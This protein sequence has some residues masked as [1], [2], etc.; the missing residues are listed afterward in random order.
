MEIIKPLR[1]GVMTRPFSWRQRE[2][3]G[4]AV[5]ALVSLRAPSQLLHEQELWDVLEDE[6]EDGAVF[7]LLIPKAHP[8]FLISGY[9]FT[10]HQSERTRCLVRAEV[11]DKAK[12]L[13][14]FGDR[15]WLAGEASAA[16]AYELQCIDWAHAYGGA[17]YPANPQGIGMEREE[18]QGVLVQRLPNVELPHALLSGPRQQPPAA[19][20]FGPLPLDT[21]QRLG[22]LGRHDQRWLEQDFPG[23]ADDLD[24][25]VFNAAP[26]D[27]Q[28]HGLATLPAGTTYAFVN[29]HPDHPLLAGSLPAGAARCFVLRDGDELEQLGEMSL[30][31]T[32]AWFFPHRECAALIYHGSVD[33]GPAA[34]VLIMPAFEASDAPRTLEHYQQVLRQ[35][36]DPDHG[37]LYTYCDQ[38]LV[39]P[40]LIGPGFD[41]D[42]LEPDAP[43][44]MAEYQRQRHAALYAEHF[45]DRPLPEGAGVAD[46]ELPT[47]RRLADLPDYAQGMEA[48]EQCWLAEA[49]RQ[50]Q[51]L[52]DDL[53]EDGPDAALQQRLQ[54]AEQTDAQPEP[55]DLGGKLALLQ[56]SGFLESSAFGAGPAPSAELAAQLRDSYRQSVQF[57]GAAPALL[58]EAAQALRERVLERY[59]FDRDLTGL[60]L[61][62]ADLSGL[63]LSGADMTGALL[64]SAN[65]TDT[66]LDGARLQRAVLA[67]A[68]LLRTSLVEADCD[69][70]NLSELRAQGA[71]LRGAR[72]TDT[73]WWEALLEECD[74]TQITLSGHMCRAMLVDCDCAGA[75]LAELD[76]QEVEFVGVSFAQASLEGVT[77]TE[78]VLEDTRFAEARLDDCCFASTL[79]D[80][81]DFAAASLV[82]CSF[83][84]DSRLEDCKFGGARIEEGNF[85]DMPMARADF[86]AAQLKDCDFSGAQLVGADLSRVNAAGTLCIATRFNAARL[87]GANLMQA[88]LQQADLRGCSLSDANLF[89]AD[90]GNAWFDASTV[91]DRVHAVRAL[92]Y[93][94]RGP[95]ETAP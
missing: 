94:R 5:T 20:G 49:A 38:D 91:L 43:G 88:I 81:T 69:G 67:R 44:P 83:A 24:W 86:R 34:P 17:A 48:A 18:V 54:A 46:E 66:R 74:L 87:D 89:E 29:L 36:L 53:P 15:Y 1:L 37:D 56:D 45:P 10:A 58:P 23:F 51:A 70:A 65:L 78:C 28:W 14:V 77:F 22:L 85:R 2:S 27:Q 52:L 60:D 40:A 82:S 76:A 42:E 73:Q 7:D 64:E 25:R 12:H 32:T 11:G 57:C 71:T 30:R 21:S 19:A 59:Q 33:A 35:R 50:R 16:Q 4:V 39:S 72:L 93:P 62:G 79:A 47:L 90:L 8:E 26:E 55:F 3:I 75:E 6:L 95:T 92:T 84:L 9:A 80:G 61:T 31:L 63:D 13:M 68:H 41:L